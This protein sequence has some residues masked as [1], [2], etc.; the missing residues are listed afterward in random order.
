MNPHAVMTHATM[1]RS[2][3]PGE[4]SIEI[5]ALGLMVTGILGNAD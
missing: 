5:S 2:L 1:H 3:Q 4:V